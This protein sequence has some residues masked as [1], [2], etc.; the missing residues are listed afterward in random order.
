MKKCQKTAKKYI[1]SAT[2]ILLGYSGGPAGTKNPDG[3]FGV[4]WDFG[5]FGNFGLEIDAVVE[6]IQRPRA[7]STSTFDPPGP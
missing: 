1:K 7:R 2:K 5:R 3:F 6:E 4:F